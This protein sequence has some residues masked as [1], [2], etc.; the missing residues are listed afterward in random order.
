MRAP[1]V[2]GVLVW[3]Q[4]SEDQLSAI[5]CPVTDI[6]QVKYSIELVKVCPLDSLALFSHWHINFMY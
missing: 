3:L 5:P 1:P 6:E 4:V 2:Q